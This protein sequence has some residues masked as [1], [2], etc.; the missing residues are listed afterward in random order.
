MSVVEVIADLFPPI[1][2]ILSFN[3]LI[4]L[5]L[6]V[7]LANLLTLDIVTLMIIEVVPMPRDIAS[8]DKNLLVGGIIGVNK[9]FVIVPHQL[10]IID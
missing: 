2:V 4:E 1:L 8:S 5:V 7:Q 6:L 3:E 10:A 9:V